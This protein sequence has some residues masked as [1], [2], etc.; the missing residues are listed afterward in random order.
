MTNWE[1][2]LGA[3]EGSSP[4]PSIEGPVEIEEDVFGLMELLDARELR[5][6]GRTEEAVQLLQ[7]SLYRDPSDTGSRR[8]LA[9]VYREKGELQEALSELS[10]LLW[11]EPSA[12]THV[13]LARVYLQMQETGKAVEEVEKALALDPEHP[14]AR[15][16]R[17]EIAPN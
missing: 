10:I 16:L 11:T 6:R 8:E 12:E 2:P 9:D 14:G 15:G 5:S 17:S 7:R 3:V 13:R 1:R 4:T